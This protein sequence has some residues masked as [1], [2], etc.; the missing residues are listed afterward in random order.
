MD[1][2]KYY[3]EVKK[4]NQIAGSLD[5]VTLEKF[6]LQLD[7]IYEEFVVEGITEFENKNPEGF[8]D[9]IVDT[10]VTVAGLMQ[11]AE[12]AGFD[13]NEALKR[14]C[15]NNLEKYPSADEKIV[16]AG[17]LTVTKNEEYN[18]WVLKD[19]NGKVKKPPSF[20]NVDLEG[21]FP[22]NFFEGGV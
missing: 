11:M 12:A 14:V 1:V 2:T 17:D 3:N 5:N 21:L 4:F 20:V 18:C 9:A 8:L 7:L 22:K 13:V 10:F 15:A 6:D 16:V 19:Q